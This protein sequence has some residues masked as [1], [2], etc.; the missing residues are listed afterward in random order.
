[1]SSIILAVTA[2]V[3]ISVL[4]RYLDKSDFGLMALVTFVM[5]F[6]NLFNDMGLTVAILHKPNISE[7][8]YSS[9]YWFNMA[10][11]IVM[12]LIVVAVAPAVSIFYDQ[13]VLNTLIPLIGINLIISGIG[14]LFNTRE[15]KLLEFKFICI[16]DIIGAI[17]SLVIAIYLAANGY[18]VYALVYS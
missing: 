3:K 10:V 7:K 16:V 1:M 8:T 17:S 4:T 6:M 18:G 11:G 9:L 13:P 12:F 5:G 15:R 2:I 14:K